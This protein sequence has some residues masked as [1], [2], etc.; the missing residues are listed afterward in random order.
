[1]DVFGISNI[2]DA[3]LLKLRQGLKDEATEKSYIDNKDITEDKI[4]KFLA[5][6]LFVIDDKPPSEYVKAIIKDH[7]AIIPEEKILDAIFAEIRD[8]QSILKNGQVEGVVI[9][10]TDEVLRYGRHLKNSEI[11]LM[12]LSRIINRNPVEKNSIP[13]SFNS[14]YSEWK[15]NNQREMLDQCVQTLCRALFNKNAA[16]A[17]WSLFENVYSLIV[18][19]P[20]YTVREIYQALDVQTRDA[21]PDFDVISLLYFISLVKDGIQQ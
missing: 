9:Q 17:F 15:S 12:A 6:V 3:A 7:P 20:K 18:A 21:Q 4:D 13:P 10:A 11:K 5:K 1:M 16:S 14:I 19:N 8:A 2:K